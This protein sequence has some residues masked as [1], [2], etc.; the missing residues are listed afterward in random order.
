[1]FSFDVNIE[2]K[3]LNSFRCEQIKRFYDF[4]EIKLSEHFVGNIETPQ[5]WKYG[6]IYGNSG[7]GKSTIAKNLGIPIIEKFEYHNI[8]VIDEMKKNLDIKEITRIFTLVGFSSVPNWLKPYNVLSNGEKMRVDFARAILEYDE[9]VFDEFTSV[10]DRE[11]AQTMC[12]ALNKIKE[13]LNKKIIF[14]TCHSDIKDYLDCDF[15]FCSNIMKNETP[16]NIKKKT[17]IFP[18]STQENGK[19]LCVITI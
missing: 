14:V 2:T 12:L 4:N 19:S 15:V 13:K 16:K 1:M 11:V 5:N 17:F 18:K 6:L 3:C 10:V 9:F 7:T 8:P